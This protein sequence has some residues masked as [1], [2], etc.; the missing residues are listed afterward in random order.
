MNSAADDRVHHLGTIDNTAFGDD[1]TES[2]A[3]GAF[4]IRGKL[5][6]TDWVF[7]GSER[8]AMVVQVHRRR[9]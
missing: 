6:G 5:R 9:G 4:R 3:A 2:M 1:R 7:C 8:P